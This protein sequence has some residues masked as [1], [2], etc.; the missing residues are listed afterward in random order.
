MMH[1]DPVQHTV[2]WS[3]LACLIVDGGTHTARQHI[4]EALVFVR[5][6]RRNE[7][8]RRTHL[9]EYGACAPEELTHK[10]WVR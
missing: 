5:M 9:Y 8:G 1:T 3:E 7:A 10:K 6:E 2:A 4:N